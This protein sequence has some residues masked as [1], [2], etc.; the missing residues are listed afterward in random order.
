MDK[1]KPRFNNVIGVFDD[2][3]ARIGPSVAGIPVLGNLDQ[4]M[5]FVR[6]NR[7]DDIIVTLPW[8]ADERLMSIISR[9]RELPANIHLGSDLVGFRFPYRPSPNHFIGIPM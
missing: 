3:H 1:E 9:L 7:V 2:R 8:N 6:S 4:M 5:R